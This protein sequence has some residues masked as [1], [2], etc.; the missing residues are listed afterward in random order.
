MGSPV[1]AERYIRFQLEHLTARNEH[2]LFE[3]ICYRI[4]KQRLS[5]NLLWATG[6]VSAGGDQGR[7]A[8][9]YYTRL[10]QELSAEGEFAGQATTEPLV[11]ACS[12]QKDGLDAKVRADVKAICGRGGT[13]R[14]I[15]FFAVQEI[16]VAAR[17]RLLDEVRNTHGVTLEIFDGQAVSRMLGEEDLVWVA[18]RFLDLPSQLVPVP[19]GGPRQPSGSAGRREIAAYLTTLIDWLDTDPWPRDRR[20]GGPALS[21][22]A[23]ERRLCVTAADAAGTHV[24]DADELVE[25]CRRVV[26]LGG[27]GSGKTWLARRTARRCAEEALQVLAAGRAADEIVLP[28]YITCARLVSAEGDIR[29]AA[30]SGAISQLGDLGGARQ[31]AAVRRFFTERDGP[32]LLVIDSLDEAH[33]ADERLRQA[34]TLPWRIVLTSRP[35]SWSGQIL[36]DERDNS[37]CVGEL[38][39]LRY[40]DDVEQFIRGWFAKRPEWGDDLVAQI[41]Q[42]ADLQQAAT[43]PLILAFYC[44]VGDGTPLPEFPHDLYTKILNRL[45]TGRWRDSRS[46]QPDVNICLQTLRAWAWAGATSHPV[47]GLG[48]WAD[49]V[50]VDSVRVGKPDEEALDHV[51]VP[52]GP[53]DV[54]TGKTLRRFIHR[55]VREHLV[56]EYV[57]GLPVDQA[58]EILLPHLWYDPDWEYAAPAA[59]ARHPQRDKLLQQI[60]CRAA[61]ADQMPQNVSAIDGGWEISALL[62]RAAIQSADDDWSP[63]AAAMIGDARVEL[64][65]RWLTDDLGGATRWPASSRRVRA[66]LLESLASGINDWKLRTLL[67]TLV[68]LDP[69]PE[70]KSQAL[71]ILLNFLSHERGGAVAV[72][73]MSW[74]MRLDPTARDERSAWN[75]LRRVLAHEDKRPAISE[76]VNGVIRFAP[77]A[78]DKR[79]A[80]EELLGLLTSTEDRW[81]AEGYVNGVVQ[82][83]LTAQDKRD[84]RETLLSLLARQDSASIASAL[85]DGLAQLGQ[86]ADDKR[87]AREA[88]LEAIASETDTRALTRLVR[89]LIKL[90]P[91]AEDKR[92]ARKTLP[93]LPATYAD[94]RRAMANTVVGHERWAREILLGL[95]ATETEGS[96]L[97]DLVSTL[98]ML[99]P[100]ADDKRR[101]REA[102][103]ESLTAA[104]WMMIEEMA[105][106]LLELNPTMQ[107]KRRAREIVVWLLASP[108]EAWMAPKLVETLI[109][110][111]PTAEDKRTAL[112]A[113]LGHIAS[114]TNGIEASQHVMASLQLAPT[115]ADIGWTRQRMLELLAVET[116]GF[117]AIDLA[118]TLSRLD[119][120]TTDKR[121][122]R[123]IL[124]GLLARTTD[125]GDASW[126][127]SGMAY[128][129]PTTNDIHNWDTWAI[130]PTV[131]LLAAVRRN[132]TI[133]DWLESI[134]SRASI[135]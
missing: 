31:S 4:A 3:E 64:A 62:A 49:D 57:A 71:G 59:L 26:I 92:R 8:E 67:S 37:A 113:Q 70:D 132:S 58:A 51:A 10:P 114:P 109:R 11:M 87:R 55:S 56:A 124:L 41:A 20:F 127:M 45:L 21:P 15:A 17:H 28:L 19:A 33:G 111:D 102:I 39:P 85:A 69:T 27:P 2:H 9:T 81:I 119:P 22:A 112:W 32:A 103:L 130:P 105:D 80:L 48:T 75:A 91:T 76:L 107:D 44:I 79:L 108:D 46:R 34:D 101:A 122:A 30:V 117:H 36:I 77:T 16:P 88:V 86:T 97:P 135:D 65:R 25:R 53:P 52:L 73:A 24:Y 18:Q 40:P 43:V 129:D 131:E 110:L 7:D 98:I 83:A 115:A 63:S 13:V 29:E 94:I 54:D 42:R 82:L 72:P 93:W 120:T 99:S 104:P 60:F 12:V 84:A 14:A 125:D 6:P 106:A 95:L 1:E 134:P 116:E 74:I 100:T 118:Q 128:L 38:Q 68:Q 126:L 35:S 133:K 50:A 96:P 5:S 123:E 23:I 121:R 66:E 47:S 61:G 90:A 78:Q 89:T